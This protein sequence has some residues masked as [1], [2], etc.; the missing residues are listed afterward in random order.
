MATVCPLCDNTRF[1]PADP[2]A[3]DAGMRRCDCWRDAQRERLV[4]DADIP[5]HD[6]GCTVS[7]FVPVGDAHR[8]VRDAVAA[9]VRADERTPDRDHPQGLLFVGPTGSGKTHL[10]CAVL[11]ALIQRRVCPGHYYNVADLM[12]EIREAQPM[13][14]DFVRWLV[15]I[16]VLL[17]DDLGAEKPTD[18]QRTQIY[19]VI[20]GRYAACRP[21]L[22]TTNLTIDQISEQIEPRVASRLR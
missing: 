22:V 10:A 2:D 6:M 9:Y 7:N 18:W 16:P 4:R 19:L 15:D 5:T 8:A 14:R 3:P 20:N 1:V 12:L 17:L 13:E 21:T 11:R